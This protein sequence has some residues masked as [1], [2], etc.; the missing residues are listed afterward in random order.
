MEVFLDA[1]VPVAVQMEASVVVAVRIV[2]SPEVA[3]ERGHCFSLK[4]AYL[5]AK[6][7]SVA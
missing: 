5:G 3:V 4:E 6:V 2:A 1:R 7:A